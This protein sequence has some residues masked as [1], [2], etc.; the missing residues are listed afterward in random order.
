[1]KDRLR[2]NICDLDDYDVL[3]EVEDLSARRENCIGS[4]LEYHVGFGQDISPASL[5]MVLTL[6]GYRRQ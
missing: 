2:K 5:A 4:S 3:S 6:S 1:M